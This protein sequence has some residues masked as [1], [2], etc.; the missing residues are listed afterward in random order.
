MF[1]EI[2]DDGVRLS[3]T[4]V[5]TPGLGDA[6]DNE[7]NIQKIES[8]IETQFEKFLQEET[9]IHRNPKAQDTRVHCVLYF[10]PPT[11]HS[12]VICLNVSMDF[13]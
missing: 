12:C 9:K 11:G 13:G 8:Y 1:S 3:L 7:P 6:L 2:E 4:V 10:I 5:D